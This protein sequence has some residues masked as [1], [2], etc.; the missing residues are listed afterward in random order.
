MISINSVLVATDFG[1]ASDAALAYGR[2]LARTFG[3]TLHL[4]HV[5]DDVLA[6]EAIV[7]GAPMDLDDAQSD[8]EADARRA[9]DRLLTEEDRRVLRGQTICLTSSRPASIIVSYAQDAGIDLLV[10]G[11]HGRSPVAHFLVGSVA[12]RIVRTAPCPVLTVRETE[13]HFERPVA[14][15]RAARR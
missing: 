11:T 2:D 3:A 8:I 1:P 6:R 15:Q 4:L 14:L 5:V 13:S 7:S 12:E 9:L 10:I